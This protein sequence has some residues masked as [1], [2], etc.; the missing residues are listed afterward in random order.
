ME[1]YQQ[2][3]QKLYKKDYNKNVK[4][5]NNENVFCFIFI[6]AFILRFLL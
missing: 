4:T 1:G 2:E 3:T 6:Y 5:E